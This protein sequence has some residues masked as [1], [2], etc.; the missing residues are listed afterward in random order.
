[1][2]QTDNIL[3]FHSLVL[4]SDFIIGLLLVC[5]LLTLLI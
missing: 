3:I 5:L 2:E 4:G 1:M